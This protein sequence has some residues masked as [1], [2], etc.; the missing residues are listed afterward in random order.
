MMIVQLGTVSFLSTT[1]A[2]IIEPQSF[3]LTHMVVFLPTLLFLAFVE[4][5]AFLMM[6][7][8]QGCAPPTHA[9]ILLSLEGVFATIAEYIFLGTYVSQ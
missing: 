9:A 4:G 2:L 3:F 7:R 8:G 5:L 1:A 6:A